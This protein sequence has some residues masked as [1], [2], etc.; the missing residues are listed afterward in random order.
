[1]TEFMV[2]R[3]HNSFTVLVRQSLKMLGANSHDNYVEFVGVVL[4]M[5]LEALFGLSQVTRKKQESLTHHVIDPF[6]S[7][8]KI[9]V[10]FSNQILFHIFYLL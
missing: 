4:L 2:L 6:N 7:F 9:S 3:I 8:S 10:A 1:M 5:V